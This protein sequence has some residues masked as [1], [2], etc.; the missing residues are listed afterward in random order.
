MRL[1]AATVALFAVAANADAAP[2]KTKKPG[3][4][5]APFIDPALVKTRPTSK[6]PSIK[7]VLDCTGTNTARWLANMR[8]HLAR[9]LGAE[10]IEP[11]VMHVVIDCASDVEPIRFFGCEGVVDDVSPDC[12]RTRWSASEN[13]LTIDLRCP[14]NTVG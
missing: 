3:N 14:S 11:I 8:S 10:V 12:E 2:K 7:F 9:T 1:A 5:F 6:P 4:T 13:E